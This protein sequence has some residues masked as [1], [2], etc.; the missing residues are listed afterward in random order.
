MTSSKGEVIASR[1]AAFQAGLRMTLPFMLSSIPFAIIFG[2]LA[3]G[4]GLSVW[5]TC[6]LSLFVFSGSAQIIAVSLLVAGAGPGAIWVATF[7]L[8][9]RHALYAATLVPYI[10]HLAAGWRLVLSAF[11]T[12]ETF[13]V[14]E[15]R[16][17]EAGH[18]RHAHWAFLGSCAGMY[19]NWNIWTVLAAHVGR[20]MQGLAGSGLE[21]GVI[22]A[23]IGMI[24]PRL[25]ERPAAIS[26]LVAGTVA[27][28]GVWLPYNLGLT[29]AAIL[30]VA[31]GAVAEGWRREAA[32]P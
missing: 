3:T 19:V 6:A 22:A 5:E 18:Q 30:G 9:L 1:R 25:K 31:A 4:A 7:I 26:A 15:A 24:V 23:F 20:E 29:L 11:L 17:R 16:Y 12:D 8:N 27:I 10:R 14:M 21:F 32:R 28:A 2:V 13:A